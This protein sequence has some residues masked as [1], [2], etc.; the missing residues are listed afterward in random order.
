M[1]NFKTFMKT[2]PGKNFGVLGWNMFQ[3]FEVKYYC[4]KAALS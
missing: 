1:A 2:Y 3:F 4:V